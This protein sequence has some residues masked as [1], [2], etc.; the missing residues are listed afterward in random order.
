MTGIEAANCGTS[1]FPASV[2]AGRVAAAVQARHDGDA[3]L[4]QVVRTDV[5]NVFNPGLLG[6]VRGGEE[7]NY[8]CHG[9]A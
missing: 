4:G 2:I 9:R 6:G 7:G 5:A 8:D 1:V 3:G